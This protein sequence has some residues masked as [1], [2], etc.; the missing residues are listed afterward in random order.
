MICPICNKKIP[1]LFDC[2][3][4]H[5]MTAYD[6]DDG[7]YSVYD[8]E[9]K[10]HLFSTKNKDSFICTVTIDNNII[11]KSKDYTFN[12]LGD[13]YKRILNNILFT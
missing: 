5:H 4:D 7:S 9:N 6:E 10:I 12:N 11:F 8:Y 1:F 3:S 2:K 13:L